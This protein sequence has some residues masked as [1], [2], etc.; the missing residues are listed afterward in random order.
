[1]AVS[2]EYL[3]L[4][5]LPDDKQPDRGFLYAIGGSN[6]NC[7][8]MAIV[9][10]IQMGPHPWRSEGKVTFLTNTWRPI[11]PMLYG[12]LGH[13]VAVHRKRSIIVAGGRANDLFENITVE[14]FLRQEDDGDGQWTSLAPMKM[15]VGKCTLLPTTRGYIC[16]GK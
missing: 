9:E 11:A 16:A 3:K 13:G 7:A 15:P 4:A 6:E 10:C 12:H 5:W 1:M 14:C 8:A 2:R